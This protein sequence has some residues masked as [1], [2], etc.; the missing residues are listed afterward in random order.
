MINGAMMQAELID[1]I[2]QLIVPVIDS[3]GTE[4]SRLYDLR[5]EPTKQAAFALSLIEQKTRSHD[6]QWL[7]HKVIQN[8]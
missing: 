7:R 4:I 6:T 8:N 2:S 3:G 1:E 5:G